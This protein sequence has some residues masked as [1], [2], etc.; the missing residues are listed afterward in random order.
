M[1]YRLVR[2]YERGKN[3]KIKVKAYVQKY[4]KPRGKAP[5][6]KE[7]VKIR[8]K[9]NERTYWLKDKEGNFTGRADAEGNTTSITHVQG[10]KDNTGFIQD[11]K[12][13]RIYGRT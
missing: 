1:P 13:K 3:K 8:P 12:Y 11:K 5:A 10:M 9:P 6:L 2:K 7:R 4:K